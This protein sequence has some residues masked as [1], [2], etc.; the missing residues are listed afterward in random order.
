MTGVV[1]RLVL[2]AMALF[3]AVRLLHRSAVARLE[4]A[5]RDAALTRA[6]EW[7]ARTHG[8][9]FDQERR[10]VPG[11]IAPY[12]GPNGPRSELRGP[13]PDQA[14]WVWGWICVVIAAFL[15]VSVVAQLSSGSV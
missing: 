10:E 9:P 5:V 3:L 11:D 2:L 14:A 6:E 7:W 4:W 15:A 1:I 12:L 8:G 13:K